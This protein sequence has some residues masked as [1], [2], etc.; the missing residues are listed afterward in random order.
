MTELNVTLEKSQYELA[1]VLPQLAVAPNVHLLV[2][3]LGFKLKI[4]QPHELL[5][6]KLET[7]L[8]TLQW[9]SLSASLAAFQVFE[10]FG[11]DDMPNAFPPLAHP[12]NYVYMLLLCNP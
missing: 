7:G 1:R 10:S 11:R 6:R 3:G 9:K 5:L 8:Q 12:K 4:K 2:W